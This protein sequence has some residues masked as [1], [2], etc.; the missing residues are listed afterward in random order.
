MALTLT[1]NLTTVGQGESGDAGTWSGNSGGFDTEIKIQNTASYTWQASKNSRTS[2]TFTP[3]TNLD[4]SAANTHLYWW[5]KNDVAGFMEAKTTGTTNTSGYHIRLT[6]GSGNFKEW[7]IAGSDT[8]GGEFKCFVLDVNS[9]TDVYA[10]SGTLQLNDID[11]ITWYVDISNSGNIRIID[12]QWNDVVRF[13]TGLTATGTDFDLDDIFTENNTSA[14]KYGILTKVG[15]T[16]FSQGRITI[17]NGATTTT[18]SSTTEKFEFL[19]RDGSG[20][21]IVS[22]ALYELTFTG[23]GC[24]ATITDGVIGGG[25]TPAAA[26]FV[27]QAASTADLTITGATFQFAGLVTFLSSSDVQN[28]KFDNCLQIDPSTGTFKFN[29]ISNYVGTEGGA[30]LW[31]SDDSNISDLDFLVCDQG[32]EYGSGSDTTTPTFSNIVFDDEAGNFDV[33]NTSGSAVTIATTGST[34]AN[35]STGS[36][37][38]FQGSATITIEVIND[39][40]DLPIQNAQTSVYLLDSP[41]TELMNEDTLATGLAVESYTGSTPVDIKWRVRK[42]EDTDNPRFVAQSGT[43]TITAANGFNQ[44][45]RLKEN[46]I[47]N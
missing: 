9:T 17:G 39:E 37:V 44:T 8:W 22:D 16:I 15:N 47:L 1:A 33:N 20:E 28:T 32:V 29:I 24:T 30:V 27:L 11:I 38:T 45:V 21:G 18:F 5:A 13:G 34:N 12:N 14:N 19:T 40:T 35:S 7:H 3:T 2:C 6:D 10:S 36:S 42:S 41:F 26:R 4:M 43:G 25:G 31:P 23:S 46:D